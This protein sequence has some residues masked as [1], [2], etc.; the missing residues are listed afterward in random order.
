MGRIETCCKFANQQRLQFLAGIT[1]CIVGFIAL[2]QPWSRPFPIENDNLVL[3]LPM[4]FLISTS[5]RHG[6]IPLWDPYSG[7]GAPI[8]T[9]FSS[10]ALSPIYLVTIALTRSVVRA[11][12]LES[13][14]ITCLAYVGMALVLRLAPFWYRQIGALSYALSGYML[15]QNY[16]NIEGAYSAAAIPWIFFGLIEI[17]HERFLGVASI[18]FGVAVSSTGGYLGMNIL[19]IYPLAMWIAWD[20]IKAN[21][22]GAAGWRDHVSYFTS[23][24]T[25]LILGLIPISYSIAETMHHGY[26]TGFLTRKIDPYSGSASLSSIMTLFGSFGLDT[27]VQDSWG[28]AVVMIFVPF[29]I[30]YLIWRGIRAGSHEVIGPIVISLVTF[31]LLLSRKYP[32]IEG[33]HSSLPGW[34]SIRYHGWLSIYVVFF[35]IFAGSISAQEY[36]SG[37]RGKHVF[38]PGAVFATSIAFALISLTL[39]GKSWLLSVGVVVVAALVIARYRFSTSALVL[40]ALIQVVISAVTPQNNWPSARGAEEVVGISNLFAKAEDGFPPVGESRLIGDPRLGWN[41]HYFLKSASIFAYQ[42]GIHPRMSNAIEAGKSEI[43]EHFVLTIKDS[44]V[45]AKIQDFR[46]NYMR[47]VIPNSFTEQALQITVPYSSN[48]K[49]VINGERTPILRSKNDFIEI[50]NV[51]PGSDIALTYRPPYAGVLL[52]IGLLAWIGIG[53]LMFVGC[54]R[55]WRS[56]SSSVPDDVDELL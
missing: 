46:P 32:I 6:V 20:R 34:K 31:I 39:S 53:I 40:I 23:L 48:W 45:S 16:L 37:T 7:G 54:L 42:P 25:G 2:S 15:I 49:A 56:R 8:F 18:A 51:P 27:T 1:G 12:F 30:I 14:F 29:A 17:K 9:V 38:I 50:Q 26:F 13:I 44:P 19:G 22:S 52:S 43:L 21:L 55:Y 4:S 28:G 41:G 10:F 47:V 5:I 36:E 11:A 33:I 24:L 3:R 35:L